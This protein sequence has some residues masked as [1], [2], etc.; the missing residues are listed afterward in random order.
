ME[1]ISKKCFEDVM[2]FAAGK[3]TPF[4]AVDI[5]VVEQKYDELK[6]NFPQ[7][8]IYYAVKANPMVEVLKSLDK[9]GSYFD[10]A[11]TFEIDELISLGISPSRMSFGNTIKKEKDIKNAYGYGIRLFATDSESDILKISRVAKG[12]KILFR[13]FC[14]GEGADWPLSRKFGAP[15][16]MIET[17]VKIAKENGL[18][19]Y[20]IS[21]HVG[22][23]QR[24]IGQWN[25]AL[26]KCKNIFDRVN[27]RCGVKLKMIN[28]GGGFPGNYIEPTKSIEY[29][30]K[31]I[32]KYL[33]KHFGSDMPEI[34]FEP[35][36]S[37]VADSGVIVSE[38]VNVASKSISEN[39]PKWLFLD[40]GKFGGLIESIDEALKYPMFTE[41][42]FLVN[43]VKKSCFIIAGPTCDSYDIL[44]EKY[45]YEF[46]ENI[47]SGDKIA[48]FTTGAYTRS[49]SAIEFNG[50]P[51]LTA[52]AARGLLKNRKLAEEI[53]VKVK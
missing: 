12:S 41:K 20:G 6:K 40:V 51:P 44:Y 33:V 31:E 22:S 29:Y 17:L 36:R 26:L 8:K 23:Q 28:M 19:P 50:I 49:Y 25:D 34:I 39:D 18:D 48:I 1:I 7:A 27:D 42:D 47:E 21:F 35:G 14:S 13:I 46:P 32:N 24:N 5:D 11:T 4:L 9:K 15:I 53:K 43:D 37:M 45:K 2:R 30:A 3:N 52:Y 16:E 10:V 38:V